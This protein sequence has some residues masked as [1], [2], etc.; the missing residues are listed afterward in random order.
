MIE[1]HQFTETNTTPDFNNA[2]P[3]LINPVHIQMIVP[4]PDYNTSVITFSDGTRTH[5]I[6]S[7]KQIKE[8]I[9]S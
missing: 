6:E 4:E 9:N 1:L 7:F 8:L 2:T 5:V 3:V